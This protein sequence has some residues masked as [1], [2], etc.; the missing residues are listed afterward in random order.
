MILC[1]PGMKGAKISLTTT[2]NNEHNVGIKS[3]MFSLPTLP[4]LR[5]YFYVIYLY[6]SSVFWLF[7]QAN[8]I[9]NHHCRPRVSVHTDGRNTLST[10]KVNLSH[11]TMGVLCQQPAHH[12]EVL[13]WFHNIEA[14]AIERHSR[15]KM[16]V[17]SSSI[18]VL[19]TKP[20]FSMR[21]IVPEHL[22][23]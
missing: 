22:M 2:N 10:S 8:L 18:Y 14:L 3:I 7:F 21:N 4:V 11:N 23:Q 12:D 19:E 13:Q 9:I 1:L 20:H 15:G 6:I 17:R 16:K 5:S